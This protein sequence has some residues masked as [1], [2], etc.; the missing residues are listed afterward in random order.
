MFETLDGWNVCDAC[1]FIP[2]LAAE[3]GY[4]I[5]HKIC[6]PVPHFSVACYI[7][8]EYVVGVWWSTGAW[9]RENQEKNQMKVSSAHKNIDPWDYEL[10]S[11]DGLD[12][13]NQLAQAP[14]IG[15]L[16][17]YTVLSIKWLH[18]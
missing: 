14:S 2:Y 11:G 4:D 8:W 13:G 18:R 16:T 12:R 5:C 7:S 6:T 15:V 10:V 9:I 17:Y 1:G 3:A